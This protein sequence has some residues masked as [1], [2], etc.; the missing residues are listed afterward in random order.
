M[1]RAA[2]W[3]YSRGLAAFEGRGIA[4]AVC[5]SGTARLNWPGTVEV[6]G[7]VGPGVPQPARPSAVVRAAARARWRGVKSC[8]FIH[9]FIPCACGIAAT[10]GIAHERH[11]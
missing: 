2:S 3:R 1:W 7:A 6:I 10:E 5:P 4:L 9:G 11:G 8:K